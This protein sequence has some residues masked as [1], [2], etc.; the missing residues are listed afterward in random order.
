[1]EK[2][3]LSIFISICIQNIYAQR[4]ANVGIFVGTAYYMGDIN[5]NKHFYR[6]R[7]SFGVIYR[8]NF[9]KRYA[10]RANGYYANLSG[11]D[12]DFIND[13]HPDRYVNPAEF[14][15]SLLDA[16]LQFEF[17]FLPYMPNTKKWNYTPYISGGI[18]YS[19]I[20]SSSSTTG[21]SALPHFTLPFSIGLK[22]TINKKVSTGIEWEFRKTMSDRIDGVMNPSGIESIIHNN[23][24]YSFAGIFITYKFFNFAVDCPAYSD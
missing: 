4:D 1:M 15:T 7:P 23:D 14:S 6:P 19:T 8:Y 18:G 2:I 12:L 16:T 5:P 20:L 24:W 21:E 3:I 17:S 9:N 22:L 13:Y 11:S 10:I